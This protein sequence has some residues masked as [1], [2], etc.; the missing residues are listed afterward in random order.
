MVS[1]R[2]PSRR[3]PGAERPLNKAPDRIQVSGL[4]LIGYCFVGNRGKS[5]F[6]QTTASNFLFFGLINFMLIHHRSHSL[7]FVLLSL[8]I[9]RSVGKGGPILLVCECLCV[10]VCVCLCVQFYRTTI[11]SGTTR[12]LHPLYAPE[13]A[14]RINIGPT[15]EESW[16][17]KL[18][19]SRGNREDK[20]GPL[21]RKAGSINLGPDWLKRS[22]IE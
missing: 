10:C 21:S 22:W 16:E 7:V 1:A 11:R 8:F 14:G 5:R 13:E 20:L 6:D 12:E 15:L 17:Y 19:P 9:F 4:V 2:A 3:P 18:G